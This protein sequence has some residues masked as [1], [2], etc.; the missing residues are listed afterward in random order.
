MKLI[1]Q[2]YPA[3]VTLTGS[4]AATVCWVTTAISACCGLW[5]I[6]E[7]KLEEVALLQ[8]F[9]RG[10]AV[11]GEW[12]KWVW[13]QHQPPGGGKAESHWCY[14]QL[15]TEPE[16]SYFSSKHLYQFMLLVVKPGVESFL[17]RKVSL[18]YNQGCAVLVHPGL[19]EVVASCMFVIQFF[20]LCGG[21]F[22]Y[23]AVNKMISSHRVVCVIPQGFSHKKDSWSSKNLC[24]ALE[25]LL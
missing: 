17:C 11:V 19:T 7:E 13:W 14:L 1:E 6:C 10:L 5:W 24:Q 16:I 25:K 12:V 22:K 3:G 4:L 18:G 21:I 8:K 2:S 20:F 15:N 23:K 9:P